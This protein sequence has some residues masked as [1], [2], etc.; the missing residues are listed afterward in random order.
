MRCV[1]E[2]EV[3]LDLERVCAVSHKS[4]G[5]DGHTQNFAAEVLARCSAKV[6][7]QGVIDG[8]YVSIVRSGEVYSQTP[9]SR[10]RSLLISNVLQSISVPQ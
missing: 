2:H 5:D 7:R 1:V 10:A 6:D 9:L 4:M 8:C 3:G